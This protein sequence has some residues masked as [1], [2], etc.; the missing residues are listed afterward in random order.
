MERCLGCSHE[1]AKTWTDGDTS[2]QSQFYAAA[3]QAGWDH[4]GNVRVLKMYASAH[5]GQTGYYKQDQPTM[6]PVP[7][8]ALLGSLGLGVAGWLRHRMAV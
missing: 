5:L 1:G 8:A 6:V 7:G 3:V 2:L 4:I